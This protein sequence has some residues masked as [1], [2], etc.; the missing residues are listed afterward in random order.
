LIAGLLN[1]PVLDWLIAAVQR[2][3]YHSDGPLLEGIVERHTL[4]ALAIP[5]KL[6]RS[7][8]GVLPR[9]EWMD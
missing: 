7:R 2:P 6:D 8:A 3:N 5:A 9:A 1:D 4:S